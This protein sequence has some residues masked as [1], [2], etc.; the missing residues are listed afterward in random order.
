[1]SRVGYLKT[2]HELEKIARG[3]GKN[4]LDKNKLE[5]DFLRFSAYSKRNKLQV[6][7]PS[8]Y[9]LNGEEKKNMEEVLASLG[10]ISPE[11]V[12]AIGFSG[13][14]EALPCKEAIIITSLQQIRADH[15]SAGRSYLNPLLEVIFQE[16]IN[17]IQNFSIHEALF[18][19]V[20]AKRGELDLTET[21]LFPERF[22]AGAYRLEVE[23]E[24]PSSTVN[25]FITLHQMLNE[26][27]RDSKAK[28]LEPR[29]I[30]E[31]TARGL[32]LR[33]KLGSLSRYEV[34]AKKIFS[35][36]TN[37]CLVEEERSSSFYLYIPNSKKNIMVYFGESPFEVGKKP[38]ALKVLEGNSQEHSLAELVKGEV[39]NPSLAV[40]ESR[41]EDLTTLYEDALRSRQQKQDQFLHLKRLIVELKEAQENLSVIAN[42]KMRTEYALKLPHEMLEF[43]VYPSTGDA[44]IHNLLAKL[45]WNRPIRDYHNTEAFK[46]KYAEADEAQKARILEEVRTNLIFRTQ[47]NEDVNFWLYQ[48]HQEFCEKQGIEFEVLENDLEDDVDLSSLEAD[49]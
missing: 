12:E 27:V 1:M 13:D 9:H 14:Y 34:P 4:G 47:Q 5:E 23:L 40:L 39:F 38:A 20:K 28:L 44:V 26:M 33:G 6:R 49:I 11:K 36:E 7:L 41:I 16:G 32:Q 19:K 3:K 43:I 29:E 25:E 35:A 21:H 31:I 45:S 18:G 42:P 17:L 10:T 46:L 2:L 48:N 37:S 30:Y 22:L 24:T 15:Y 8:L